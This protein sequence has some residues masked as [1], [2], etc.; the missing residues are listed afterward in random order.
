MLHQKRHIALTVMFLISLSLSYVTAW[1]PA[2]I[3]A[4]TT[5]VAQL[6]NSIQ[7]SQW[8]KPS[9]D[10]SGI[11]YWPANDTLMIVDG[12]V[13][14]MS[15]PVNQGVNVFE[16]TRSGVLLRTYNVTPF[17]TEPVGVEIEVDP[18][19]GHFF[20]SDD[21][22]KTVYDIDLGPDRLFRTSDDIVRS[23]LTTSFGN[24]D[25]EGIAIGGGRM[26]LTDGVGKQ[27]FVLNPGPNGRYEGVGAG[28]DDTVTSWSTIPVNQVDPEGVEYRDG[29]LY[30][31]SNKAGAN[32][33]ETDI[34][35]TLL[36]T[37]DIQS[38]QAVSPSDLTFAPATS[39]GGQNLFIT[40][41][42]SIMPTTQM[43]MTA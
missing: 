13:E 36:R 29:K 21:S 32:V 22:H 25:P 7:T 34:N 28:K 3:Q 16:T 2:K 18:I 9:P 37:I 23:F 41:G 33:S 8:N 12:E 5:I 15:P 30:I 19:N 4:A 31:V 10:P 1:R 26:Y 27:I 42:A 14:E 38:L 6:V 39:G 40:A 24:N 35:G 17:T 11:S 43:R 20:I